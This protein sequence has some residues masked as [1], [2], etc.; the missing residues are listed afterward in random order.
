MKKLPADII[1]N[2]TVSSIEHLINITGIEVTK[3]SIRTALYDSPEFPIIPLDYLVNL[4]KTWRIESLVVKA[5]VEILYKIEL[6]AI[7][8][9]S[10][11]TDLGIFIII[12]G[13]TDE[14]V[15]Y[16][17]PGNG[18]IKE[19][20]CEFEL[21]C[22]NGILIILEPDED[23][24]GEFEFESKLSLENDLSN[25]Y[26]NSIK[27]I[28]DFLTETE[29]RELIDYCY[30]ENLFSRSK[31]DLSNG[32]EDTEHPTRTSFSAIIEDR[33]CEL[34]KR[35]FIKASSIL[36]RPISQIEKIQCVRYYPTQQFGL[37]FDSSKE[38]NREYTLL[39][40]LNEDFS[41]G[42]TFFPEIDLK[43][44]PKIGRCIIFKNIDTYHENILHSVHSGL[45]VRNGIKYACNIWVRYT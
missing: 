23:N 38:N 44:K 26:R 13:V 6:P 32:V 28:D 35:L 1:F 9:I 41:E 10:S 19:L 4:L 5:D 7:M 24:L 17:L 34:S 37:H 33:N 21:K 40:Y 29:C 12:T 15:Y 3:T 42:E 16:F 18:I 43:I 2:T 20:I 11:G 31:V 39:I 14:F 30:K 25:E 36:E 8:H 27:I 22:V 45:P